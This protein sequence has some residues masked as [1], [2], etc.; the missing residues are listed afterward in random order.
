ME[1]LTT[2]C[3]KIQALNL[4]GLYDITESTL[5]SIALHCKNI[6]M[7]NVTGCEGVTSSGLKTLI[8][9]LKY[10]EQSISFVGFKPI[11][12]HVNKKLEE[13]LIMVKTETLLFLEQN[14]KA[15]KKKDH[16]QEMFMH[17][18][19]VKSRYSLTHLT[20]YSLTHLITYSLKQ[21]NQAVH[22]SLHEASVLLV[23]LL[24]KEG[25]AKH[26]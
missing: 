12:E 8:L 20:T 26:Y 17:R 21:H 11:D 7:L 5:H 16:E 9:G 25:E 3:S 24:Q 14:M 10:V 23:Y 13:H 2:K 6:L 22:E 1:A 19:Q 4:S 15:K 18:L